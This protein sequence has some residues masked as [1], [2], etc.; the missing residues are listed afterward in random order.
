MAKAVATIGSAAYLIFMCMPIRRL[1]I[2][3]EQT[4]IAAL[5]RRPSKRFV[6]RQL[7]AVGGLELC[8]NQC[9]K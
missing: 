5:K 4:E 2:S 3:P 8:A 9:C 7:Y 1:T 6:F